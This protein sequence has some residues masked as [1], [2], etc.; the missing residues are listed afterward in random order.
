MFVDRNSI[1]RHLVLVPLRYDHFFAPDDL[2]KR[3][4]IIFGITGVVLLI[5]IVF[6]DRNS[7]LLIEIRSIYIWCLPHCVMTIS[8][9]A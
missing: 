3:F 1:N 6:V 4:A 5:E 7:C 8:S 9:L 2:Q